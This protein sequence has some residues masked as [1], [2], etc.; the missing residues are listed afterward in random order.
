MYRAVLMALLCLDQ[1]L[2]QDRNDSFGLFPIE[3]ETVIVVHHH[4]RQSNIERQ[5]LACTA[6]QYGPARG[7]HMP[8]SEF[9]VDIRIA[10][11][12]FGEDHGV[13]PQSLEHVGMDNP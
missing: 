11:R 4:S 7:Q 13:V 10:Q 9:V 6:H 8:D 1:V 12:Q 3:M 5:R 2:P